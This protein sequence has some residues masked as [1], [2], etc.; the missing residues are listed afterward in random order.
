MKVKEKETARNE[1]KREL[2]ERRGRNRFKPWWS[3]TFGLEMLARWERKR[4]ES[5]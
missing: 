3:C 4:G 2:L 1:K 5:R